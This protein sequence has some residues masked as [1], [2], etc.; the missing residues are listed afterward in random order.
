MGHPSRVISSDISIA[1]SVRATSHS[2]LFLL[3]FLRSDKLAA[4]LVQCAYELKQEAEESLFVQHYATQGNI[5]FPVAL[6]WCVVTCLGRWVA[7]LLEISM[8]F[9]N[10][11]YSRLPTS[12]PGFK[13]A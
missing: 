8:H 3:P 5:P 7:I 13:S 11:S 2:F 10:L 6:I 9:T 4:I 12:S 1:S